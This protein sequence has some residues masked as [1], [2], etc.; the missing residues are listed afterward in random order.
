MRPVDHD[1]VADTYGRRYEE[2]EYGGVRS[3]VLEFAVA[4]GEIGVLEVGC[5]TGHW[6]AALAR[7]VT[8]VIGLDN[9]RGM[10]ARARAAVPLAALVQG[11]AETLPFRTA[12]LDRVLSVN[13]LHHFSDPGAFFAEARRVLRPGGGLLTTG[14]D[15]HAGRD[16]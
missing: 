2:H 3:T 8:R 12:S 13:A 7:S 5:S 10:V 16:R 14:L 4:A 9:S 6:L 11:Q 1:H 15:P